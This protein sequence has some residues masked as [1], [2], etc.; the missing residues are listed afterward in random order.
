MGETV[1]SIRSWRKEFMIPTP[2]S[3][4]P[5][6]KDRGVESLGAIEFVAA[7]GL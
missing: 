6:R 1:P 5:D 4:Y 2:I 7:K 3:G